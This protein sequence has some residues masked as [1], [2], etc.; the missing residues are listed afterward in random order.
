MSLENRVVTSMHT[1]TPELAI[2]TKKKFKPDKCCSSASKR[3][4]MEY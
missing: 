4:E 1:A 3:D 2:K